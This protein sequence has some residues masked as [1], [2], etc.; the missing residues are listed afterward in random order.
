VTS[1]VAELAERVAASIL[2]SVGVMPQLDMVDERT[3]LATS[4]AGKVRRVAP[5]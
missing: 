4:P 2:E 1:D 5:T 3:L